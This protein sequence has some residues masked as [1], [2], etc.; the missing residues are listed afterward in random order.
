MTP[1][2]KRLSRSVTPEEVLA[3]HS[4]AVRSLAQTL[5]RLVKRA[6]PTAVAVAYPVWHGIGYRDPDGGYFCAIF[7]QA[8]SVRLG[9]EHGAR[10]PDP[11][12][13]LTGSGRQVRYVVITRPQQIR[14][15][16][17]A[18]LLRAAVAVGIAR[19]ARATGAGIMVCRSG[20]WV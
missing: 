13:L 10:M 1:R 8:D 12:G 6:V 5:G 2:R 14:P 17:L 11:D 16:A 7:P 4:A 18:R 19:R 20:S 9:F 3:E 15:A